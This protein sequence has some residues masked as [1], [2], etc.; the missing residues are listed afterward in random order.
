MLIRVVQLLPTGSS[1]GWDYY[2]EKYD[3]SSYS[4]QY[5]TGWEDV[6]EDR[7]KEI[8]TAVGHLNNCTN[9]KYAIIR[10]YNKLKTDDLIEQ[11]NNIKKAQEKAAKAREAY[12]KAQ[13]AE[14]AEKARL[15]KLKQLE[16]LKKELN[17]ESSQ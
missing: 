3:V 7:L 4:D 13:A 2:E 5:S 9:M 11:A 16:K 17:E 10:A 8:Q 12:N 6:S 15:R 14:K 1:D